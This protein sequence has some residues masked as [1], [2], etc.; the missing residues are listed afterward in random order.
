MQVKSRATA[1][2]GRAGGSGTDGWRAAS[3]R[4]AAL[5]PRPQRLNSSAHVYAKLQ[6]RRM[7][8]LTPRCPSHLLSYRCRTAASLAF[9]QVASIFAMAFWPRDAVCSL[10]AGM[11][12]SQHAADGLR[13]GRSGL[14]TQQ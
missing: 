13:V 2:K 7:L 6:H 5:S 10:Q 9:Q 8:R 4:G 1:E 12:E 14:R 11:E 3:G